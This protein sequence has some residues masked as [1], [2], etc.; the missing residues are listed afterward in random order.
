MPV[1]L[2]TRRK[3]HLAAGRFCYPPDTVRLLT[4]RCYYCSCLH[5]S[6]TQNI[7]VR[8]LYDPETSSDIPAV[9]GLGS[10]GVSVVGSKVSRAD[11]HLHVKRQTITLYRAQQ[12]KYASYLMFLL[13]VSSLPST[14]PGVKY[15]ADRG[16]TLSE[17]SKRAGKKSN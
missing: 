14:G 9:T 16:R 10:V 11:K 7:W 6:Q 1:E 17:T 2:C 15:A 12:C 5:A 13:M 8:G 4:V 3:T